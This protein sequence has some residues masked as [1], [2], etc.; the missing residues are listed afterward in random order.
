MLKT[1]KAIAIVKD[2]INADN[3]ARDS[4]LKLSDNKK[5]SLV[6]IERPIYLLL[7]QYIFFV[8]DE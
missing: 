3:L 2:E 6:I 7:T 8:L 1:S 5:N 4:A